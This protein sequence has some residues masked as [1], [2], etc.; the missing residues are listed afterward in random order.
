LNLTN[1]HKK[2]SDQ[3][4]KHVLLPD[5]SCERAAVSLLRNNRR[6]VGVA[7]SYAVIFQEKKGESSNSSQ[8]FNTSTSTGETR[9]EGHLFHFT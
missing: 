4:C 7:S 9:K 3:T 6:I 5:F 8:L 2:K 1:D